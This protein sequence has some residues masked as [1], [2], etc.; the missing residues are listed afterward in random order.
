MGTVMEYCLS[1]HARKRARQR[2]ILSTVVDFVL[3]HADVDLEAGD[4]CRAL[5]ISK[6]ELKNLR[7]DEA[8]PVEVE[9]AMNVIVIVCEDNKD[10]V[11]VMRDCNSRG[12]RYRRQFPTWKTQKQCLRVA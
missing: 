11:T 10:V 5:R 8:S 6:H 4:N 3:S 1:A 12:R 9:R 7:R 2:G